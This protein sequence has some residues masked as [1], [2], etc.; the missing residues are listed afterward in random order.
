MS[1]FNKRGEWKAENGCLFIVATSG[2]K[3]RRSNECHIACPL[4]NSRVVNEIELIEA[5][6]MHI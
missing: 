3:T 6:D 5:K 2:R 1:I 4:P